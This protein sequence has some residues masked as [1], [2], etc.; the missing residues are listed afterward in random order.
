MRRI[1]ASAVTTGGREQRRDMHNKLYFD[2]VAQR[3]PRRSRRYRTGG[4]LRF[5]FGRSGSI[6]T[7]TTFSSSRRSLALARTAAADA[8]HVEVTRDGE[9]ICILPPT[10]QV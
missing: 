9:G 1:A 10:V 3:N 7:G 5:Q 4:P 8:T 2:P 6:L